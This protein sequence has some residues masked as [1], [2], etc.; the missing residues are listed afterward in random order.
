VNGKYDDIIHLEH[1]VSLKHPRM[2]IAD[3]AAQFAPFAALTGYD[4]AIDE[5][6]R[7]TSDM[8]EMSEDAKELLDEWGFEYR[9]MFVWDKQKIG[10]GNLVRMQCEF[11]LMGIKGNP[12]FRDAHNIRDIFSEPR[13]EH[14]RKPEAFYEMVNNLCVGRKLDYFSREHRD[15]WCSYGNDTEKF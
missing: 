5:T 12:V 3:R 7:Y 15:G 6:G 11:C 14:S 8:A 1:P 4:D 2:P 13:R 9:S 10:M